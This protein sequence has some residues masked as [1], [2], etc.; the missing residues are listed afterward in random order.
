M[1]YGIFFLAGIFLLLC[2]PAEGADD[3][4]SG[5]VARW[6]R[7]AERDLAW[8][9][10][11]PILQEDSASE[12]FRIP[13]PGKRYLTP[14]KVP[15]DWFYETYRLGV[16]SGLMF[17]LIARKADYHIGWWVRVY[18][19][20][21]ADLGLPLFRSA[22]EISLGVGQSQSSRAD[23]QY[24]LTSNYTFISVRGIADFM[25][26][27]TA[28]LF[29]FGG[30]GGGLEFASGHVVRTGGIVEDTHKTNFN[31]LME[32]GGGY[33]FELSPGFY[34]ETRGTITYPVGSP[35]VTFFILAELGVQFL[36]Q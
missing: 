33:A 14:P 27:A 23:Q 9:E 35:N 1:R 21:G 20:I 19:Q 16:D 18:G 4:P 10:L 2:A 32:A 12:Y 26:N 31:L 8:S 36:F 29:L 5:D 3:A 11:A 24:R 7:A 30:L 13:A 28:D 22:I 34:I 6:I 17:P 25:P 15:V